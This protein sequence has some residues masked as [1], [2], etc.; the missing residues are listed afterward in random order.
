[1][2]CRWVVPPQTPEYMSR[3]ESA[4]RLHSVF[5]LHVLQTA[6]P[7]VG[8]LWGG[9]GKNVSR[10]MPLHAAF[11]LHSG[12]AATRLS[13]RLLKSGSPIRVMFLRAWQYPC[14]NFQFQFDQGRGFIRPERVFMAASAFAEGE[15]TTPARAAM[16]V[17]GAERPRAVDPEFKDGATP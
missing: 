16:P 1:M 6:I 5:T 4:S 13:Y 15:L 10:G 12:F 11:F 8:L 3:F 2:R 7:R 17:V 9:S 14:V